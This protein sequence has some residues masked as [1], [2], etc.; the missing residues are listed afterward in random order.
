M[1][2]NFI[3]FFIQ[4]WLLFKPLSCYWLSDLLSFSHNFLSII[5]MIFFFMLRIIFGRKFPYWSFFGHTFSTF[6]ILS[7][8]SAH[9]FDI[10]IS[11]GS[12]LLI[13][14]PSKIRLHLTK[15]LWAFATRVCIFHKLIGYLPSRLCISNILFILLDLIMNPMIKRIISLLKTMFRVPCTYTI[16]LGISKSIISSWIGS[17]R[18]N[19][20]LQRKL[21][22]LFNKS[23]LR[24]SFLFKDR[25]KTYFFTHDRWAIVIIL[26]FEF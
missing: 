18:F 21:S 26:I 4:F 9:L 8:L 2:Q 24:S 23:C 1:V 25:W 3:L 14:E 7:I 11:I 19:H 17:I 22:R 6:L 20:L 5:W 15:S 10:N 16:W 13:L 12:H